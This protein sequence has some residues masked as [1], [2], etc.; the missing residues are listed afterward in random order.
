MD[1]ITQME[2]VVAFLVGKR[3]RYKDLTVVERWSQ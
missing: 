2:R 3:I 1:T